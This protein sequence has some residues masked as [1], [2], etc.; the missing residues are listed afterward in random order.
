MVHALL[1]SFLKRETYFSIPMS[2]WYLESHMSQETVEE[3]VHEGHFTS[4]RY[5]SSNTWST[6][7]LLQTR[8]QGDHTSSRRP[9]NDVTWLRPQG[10][11][12]EKREGSGFLTAQ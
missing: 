1:S 2:Q 12:I 8:K 4:L 6:P 9:C 11:S 3:K 5:P 7:L 10:R